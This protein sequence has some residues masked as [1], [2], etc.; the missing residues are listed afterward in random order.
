[1]LR[2]LTYPLHIPLS[3]APVLL[4]TIDAFFYGLQRWRLLKD[5]CAAFMGRQVNRA[6]QILTKEENR[7]RV[8]WGGVGWGGGKGGPIG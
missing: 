3:L 5:T 2:L 6:S 4:E 1:M 7:K 8:G